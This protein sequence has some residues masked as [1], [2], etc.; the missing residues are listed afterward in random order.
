MLTDADLALKRRGARAYAELARRCIARLKPTAPLR[1]V[2][3]QRKRV[4]DIFPHLKDLNP[5]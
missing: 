5:K 1:A 3:P 2:E 4:Q